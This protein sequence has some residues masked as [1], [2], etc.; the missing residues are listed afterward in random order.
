MSETESEPAHRDPDTL[1][2]LYHEEG[3]TL[4]EVGE[5]LGIGDEAVL[6]WMSKHDIER[7]PQGSNPD[8]MLSPAEVDTI[9]R[10][11]LDGDS[12]EAIGRDLGCWGRSV[13]R[14]A[15]DEDRGDKTGPVDNL[16]GLSVWY[17][18]GDE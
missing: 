6:R 13:C 1:R 5:R 14:A 3:L 2:R 12:A 4:S 11:L 10:R 15:R 7:R 18:V 9:R 8:T 17:E 16:P